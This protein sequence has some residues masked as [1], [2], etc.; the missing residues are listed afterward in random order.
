[1]QELIVNGPHLRD[2]FMFGDDFTTY[3]N[4]FT[5]R[6]RFK[7]SVFE[8]VYENIPSTVYDG[9]EDASLY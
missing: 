7:Y 2:L 4:D 5:W 3:Y 6:K 9:P 1:M 8:S